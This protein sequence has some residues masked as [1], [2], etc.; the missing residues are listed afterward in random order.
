MCI[1]DSGSVD[2]SLHAVDV[3]CEG[4]QDNALLRAGNETLKIGGNITL[5]CRY[6]RHGGIGGIT[7][8]E[9]DALITVT[10]QG[11]Q[12]GWTIIQWGLIQLDITGMDDIARWGSQHDAQ[13]VRYGVVNCPEANPEWSIS[14]VGFF[15]N[16]D[17]LRLLTMFL[18]LR[19]NERDGKA[20]SNNRDIWAQLQQPRNSSDVILVRVSND[21]GLDLVDLL[22]DGAKVRQDKIHARLTGRREE[23]TAVNDEEVITCLLYTSDAADE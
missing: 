21:E 6:T 14:H 10:R 5:R 19:S 15:I 1:R 4:S 18:T 13:G 12:I 16:L 2:S 22:L 8:H 11:W 17:E 23:H 9:V 7:Q 20:G 3:G